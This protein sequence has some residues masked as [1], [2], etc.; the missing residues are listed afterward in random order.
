MKR[1]T[2]HEEYRRQENAFILGE[3]YK[4]VYNNAS[5]VK[6]ETSSNFHKFDVIFAFQFIII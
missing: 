2:H 4:S 6:R 1:N 5:I 3:I